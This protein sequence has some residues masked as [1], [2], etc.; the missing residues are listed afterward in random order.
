MK[1]HPAPPQAPFLLLPLCLLLV[2]ITIAP[3]SAVSST[4][5]SDRDTHTTNNNYHY[6]ANDDATWAVRTAKLSDPV[7]QAEYDAFMAACRTAA[8]DP[9]SAVQY[10]D[11][12]E[13][14]R[15]QMNMYQPESVRYRD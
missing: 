11:K 4:I 7:K 10:C 13:A 5:S 1:P 3:C 15:L 12:D 9:A 8:G 2:A 14:Y 6:T